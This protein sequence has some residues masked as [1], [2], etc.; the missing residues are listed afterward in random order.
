MCECVRMKRERSSNQVGMFDMLFAAAAAAIECSKP[1]KEDLENVEI[2]FCFV[3]CGAAC[4]CR[5]RRERKREDLTAFVRFFC[6]IL[7][8]GLSNFGQSTFLAVCWWGVHPNEPRVPT[9]CTDC[10]IFSRASLVAGSLLLVLLSS[11][12]DSNQQHQPARPL[13]TT[14]GQST[15]TIVN[16][17]T[18]YHEQFF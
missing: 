2:I 1:R 15:R 18:S 4:C 5:C 9:T 16:M 10:S 12:L 17:A 6:M 8:T 7:L 3:S 11:E 14:I 13:F